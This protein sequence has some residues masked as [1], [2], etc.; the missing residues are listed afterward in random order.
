MAI[1]KDNVPQA[2]HAYDLAVITNPLNPIAYLN[3]GNTLLGLGE[4]ETAIWNYDR[5]I[6]LTP[7]FAEV[8]INRGVAYAR[9]DNPELALR[10]VN[11][12]CTLNLKLPGTT[13]I[14]FC[15]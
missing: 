8:Y 10:D 5:A 9:M 4:Y 2:L 12:A 11:Y 3:R 14:G 15:F 6:Q 1:E 13:S 7:G